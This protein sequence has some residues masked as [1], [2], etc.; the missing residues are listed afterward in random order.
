[1][2]HIKMGIAA[3]AVLLVSTA[4]AEELWFQLWS[5]RLVFM[6]YHVERYRLVIEIPV[7]FW[8]GHWVDFQLAEF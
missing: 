2:R 3:M 1:M 6:V 5:A 4:G 8:V 7:F